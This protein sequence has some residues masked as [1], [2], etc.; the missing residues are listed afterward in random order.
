M[1]VVRHGKKLP[2]MVL[3]TSA[4]EVCK[5]WLNRAASQVILRVTS[6]PMS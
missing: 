1:W 2:R 3:D 4:L 6:L 5:I